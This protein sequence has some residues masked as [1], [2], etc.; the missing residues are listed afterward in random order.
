MGRKKSR[1]KKKWGGV[2][3]QVVGELY[4]PLAPGAAGGGGGPAHEHHQESI[5]AGCGSGSSKGL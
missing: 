3:Y 1:F 5:Q 2:D 4:T